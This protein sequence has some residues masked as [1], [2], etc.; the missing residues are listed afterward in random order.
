[1]FLNTN[2]DNRYNNFL[3]RDE[4]RQRGVNI[5]DDLT[6]CLLKRTIDLMWLSKVFVCTINLFMVK[7]LAQFKIL[8]RYIEQNVL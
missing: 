5:R 3:V 8:Y 1:M 7:L 4:N 6:E 2:Y